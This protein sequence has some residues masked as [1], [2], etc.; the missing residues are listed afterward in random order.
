MSLPEGRKRIM[1]NILDLYRTNLRDNLDLDSIIL[2]KYIKAVNTLK[3]KL[4]DH[5]H[6]NAMREIAEERER[7]KQLK[8]F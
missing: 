8:L 1:Q 7:Q 6:E 3:L 2:D 4:M 5:E